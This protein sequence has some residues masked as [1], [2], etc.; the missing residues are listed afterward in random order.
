MRTRPV[1][2]IEAGTLAVGVQAW[3]SETAIQSRI[4][5]MNLRAEEFFMKVS[6]GFASQGGNWMERI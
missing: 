5:P 1:P 4:V 6:P 3:D 2:A